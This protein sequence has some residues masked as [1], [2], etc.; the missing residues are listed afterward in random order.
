MSDST[1]DRPLLTMAQERD[2]EDHARR[3]LCAQ[4]CELMERV[5]ECVGFSPNTSYWTVALLLTR[6]SDGWRPVVRSLDRLAADKA[7]SIAG[8][9]AT[10]QK[11]SFRRAVTE[12]ANFGILTVQYSDG[13]K[14]RRTRPASL[15]TVTIDCRRLECI[16]RDADNAKDNETD[17]PRTAERTTR[18]TDPGQ[19]EG[20]TAE[21][22]ICLPL[23]PEN[24]SS[25][26]P[27]GV[28]GL[29][30]IA[31]SAPALTELA[32]SAP[33]LTEL[34]E[35]G[36]QEEEEELVLILEN[37]EAEELSQLVDAYQRV[38]VW[39]ADELLPELA[40]SVG[41]DYLRSL[42]EHF[43]SQEGLGEGA[44]FARLKRSHPELPVDR[45]WPRPKRTLA[46]RPTTGP[47]GTPRD[48]SSGALPAGCVQAAWDQASLRAAV[49]RQLRDAGFARWYRQAGIAI[50][51]PRRGFGRGTEEELQSLHAFDHWARVKKAYACNEAVLAELNRLAKEVGDQHCWEVDRQLQ[52]LETKLA[53]G[54]RDPAT[55][56]EN[57]D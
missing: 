27:P 57:D 5:L 4:R 15:V 17:R 43:E 39:S 46:M 47:S 3:R 20:Q 52:A 31:E 50:Q 28:R 13:E 25:P 26:S 38:G 29:T 14:R 53:T 8:A 19:R 11:R 49:D 30:E 51:I 6:L 23:V 32:E 48:A 36:S 37:S 2:V 41:I 33:A 16:L 18:R 54:G 56:E 10:N 22:S 24:P 40:K 35:R 9:S 21:H 1:A 45:G 44:L 34:A 7:L 55:V 12:L 42:L